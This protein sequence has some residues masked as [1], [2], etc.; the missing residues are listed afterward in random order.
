M[1]EEECSICL[2]PLD[3]TIT[4]VGCCFKKFHTECLIKCTAIKNE[5]PLCRANNCIPSEETIL[6]LHVEDPREVIQQHARLNFCYSLL[7]FSIL[8]IIYIKVNH[9]I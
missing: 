7:T 9:L 1:V 6:L 3:G 8:T 2:S 4:T 5:C